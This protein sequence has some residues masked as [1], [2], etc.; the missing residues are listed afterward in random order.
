MYQNLFSRGGLSLDRLRVLVEV[1]EAG[2]IARA[3]GDDSVR[4]SQYSRQLKE[5][6]EFFETALTQRDG[7][8]L[9]LT[10]AGERLATIAREGFC[11]LNDFAAECRGEQVVFRIG[12]G[13]SVL[14]WLLIPR[15]GGLREVAPKTRVTLHNL[16]SAEV[17]KQLGDMSLDFGLLRGGAVPSSCE[18]SS[19][20]KMTY[21]LYVPRRLLVGVRRP[22]AQWVLSR[23]PV[24][25][26]EE[27]GEFGRTLRRCV[28]DV[29]IR[30]EICLE[31]ESLPEVRE[32]VASG[33]FVGIL[34]NV[35][36]GSLSADECVTIS[37]PLFAK[38]TREISLAW[39]PRILRLRPAS[40]KTLSW[41]QK[42]LRLPS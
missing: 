12:A 1:A 41:L 29:S 21:G 39:N 2:G 20:G 8:R 24:A 40:A 22:T 5:L 38:L 25:S 14:Q 32:A 6:E 10:P 42:N 35:A 15:I 11:G 31:C 16:R 18:S 23:L 7:K 3:V 27:T 36:G 4:Q 34:P 19:L 37:S 30:M 17:A 28:S 9:R 33:E 13:D 26:L